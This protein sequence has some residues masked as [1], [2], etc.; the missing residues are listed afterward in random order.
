VTPQEVQ[1]FARKYLVKTHRTIINRVPVA[2]SSN[3]GS[4]EKGG[5]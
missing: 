2:A 1:A 4:G 3:N 5:R